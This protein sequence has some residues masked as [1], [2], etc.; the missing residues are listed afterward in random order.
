MAY[1]A[2]ARRYP[3]TTKLAKPSSIMV[4]VEGSGV[5]VAIENTIFGALTR[6]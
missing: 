5:A 1:A 6:R 2:L 3:A 4:H